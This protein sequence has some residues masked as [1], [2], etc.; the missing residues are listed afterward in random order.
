M[1]G[2]GPWLLSA[3]KGLHPLEAASMQSPMRQEEMS[4]FI[5]VGLWSE[6]G[7]SVDSCPGNPTGVESREGQPEAAT[8]KSHAPIRVLACEN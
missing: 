4:S 2:S 3:D 1:K 5:G 8:H 7:T 6:K